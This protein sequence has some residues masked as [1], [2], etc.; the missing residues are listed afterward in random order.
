MIDS[1]AVYWIWGIIGLT[2]L[3]VEML[4]GTLYMLWFAVAA[5]ILGLITWILPLLPITWQLLI[6]AVL[7]LGTLF[8][9]RQYY[10]RNEH[11]YKV[12]QSQGDEI[13]L[14]GEVIET[15]LLHQ[16]GRIRFAQGVMGSREW[17]AVSDQSIE[18]GQQAQIVAIEGN[19]LR[20]KKI[21][22]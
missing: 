16:T 7:S 2:L 20:V 18:T 4:T 12:G 22:H 17:N 13:G 3:G 19:T 8:F 10:D 21:T 6:Y 1:L 5:L 9:Y 11:D 14:V 15:I